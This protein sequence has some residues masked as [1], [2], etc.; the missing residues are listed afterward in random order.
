MNHDSKHNDFEYER[1]NFPKT[2]EHFKQLVADQV[3]KELNQTSVVKHSPRKKWFPA[4]VAAA[5]IVCVIAGSTGVYASV[6]YHYKSQ[7]YLQDSG[8]ITSTD[9]AANTTSTKADTENTSTTTVLSQEEGLDTT[10]TPT[11][12]DFMLENYDMYT[13]A[14][15]ESQPYITV[16]DAY[17]D[18]SVLSIY[19]QA[20]EFG[21]QTTDYWY[22]P[23]RIFINDIMFC[24]NVTVNLDKMDSH[25]EDWENGAFYAEVEL[26]DASLPDQIHVEIPF[27]A[28]SDH[29][30]IKIQ[31]I[32]FD[33]TGKSL[34]KPEVTAPT[35]SGAAVTIPET[36]VSA[37][38]TYF[39]TVWNFGK[40]KKSYQKFADV[41]NSDNLQDWIFCK[42][43]DSTGMVYDS[44]KEGYSFQS[45][46]FDEDGEHWNDNCASAYTDESGNYC[47]SMQVII[48]KLTQDF[49]S[50]EV[51]PYVHLED[52]TE[53]DLDFA[54]FRVDY[55]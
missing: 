20:T 31:T 23:D 6:R 7:E 4:K 2:P 40:D 3:E 54:S 32:S 49:T 16:L 11:L 46:Y 38:G 21:M 33:I 51:T 52:G 36:R 13:D 53:T 35:V 47:I 30:E 18:G 14:V 27:C 1:E 26:S 17:Y 44:K 34:H 37:S 25:M 5:V 8:R 12:P 45:I 15:G 10:C 42:I 29:D 19:G 24:P 9:S 28:D 50:L 41:I 43:T 55:E 39:K 22:V 48:P